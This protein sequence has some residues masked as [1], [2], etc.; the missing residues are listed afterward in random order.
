LIDELTTT[1]NRRDMPYSNRIHTLFPPL[2]AFVLLSLITRRLT[3]PPTDSIAS[4][5]ARGVAP[6][7]PV[8]D[9]QAALLLELEG[10]TGP[11]HWLALHNFYVITRYNRS[12]LYAMAVYQLSQEIRERHASS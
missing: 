10:R 6:L 4:W 7:A 2:L 9:R 5:R 3:T 8:G 12:Q 1:E 11:E